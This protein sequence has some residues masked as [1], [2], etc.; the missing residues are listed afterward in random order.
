MTRGGKRE[1]AGRP[2]KDPTVNYH[3]RVKPEWVKFLDDLL[4]KL[5]NSAK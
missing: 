4:E 5:K 3:R 2:K 1:G